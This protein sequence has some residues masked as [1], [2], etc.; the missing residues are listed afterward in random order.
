MG[1]TTRRKVRPRFMEIVSPP[2]SATMTRWLFVGSIQTSWVSPP[3][4]G[5]LSTRLRPPS[6]DMENRTDAK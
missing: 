3:P 4:R 5:G 1:S 2:S 6:T